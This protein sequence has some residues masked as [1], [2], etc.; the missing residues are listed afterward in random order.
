MSLYLVRLIELVFQSIEHRI[1][2]FFFLKQFFDCFKHPFQKVFQIF[3]SL[4]DLARLHSNFLSFSSSIFARLSSLK[5][6]KTILSLFLVL[7]SCFHAFFHTFKG[8]FRTFLDLGFLFIQGYFS[9]ID[10]WVLLGY[11]YIHDCCWLI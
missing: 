2:G 9:E 11:C 3:L 10:Q 4:S 8:Y 6:G 5:A 1:S 7:F